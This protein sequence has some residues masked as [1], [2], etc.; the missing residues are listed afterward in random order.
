MNEMLENKMK[1]VFATALNDANDYQ[2]DRLLSCI[3]LHF[4]VLYEGSGQSC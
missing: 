2:E 4:G 3:C 1:F